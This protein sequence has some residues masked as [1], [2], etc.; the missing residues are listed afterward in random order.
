VEVRE[1]IL[2]KYNDVPALLRE[3][4]GDRRPGRATTD[5]E[6]IAFSAILHF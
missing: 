4:R 5:D 6:N 2:F 1:S 3:E